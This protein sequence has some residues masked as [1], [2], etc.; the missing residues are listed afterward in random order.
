M[1]VSSTI[2]VLLPSSLTTLKWAMEDHLRKA[3]RVTLHRLVAMVAIRS[4][5]NMA[6]H[7]RDTIHHRT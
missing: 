3:I 7:L 4:P 5:S 2:T 1:A 6:D